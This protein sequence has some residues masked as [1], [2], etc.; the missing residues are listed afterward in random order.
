MKKEY[1]KPEIRVQNFQL[2]ESIAGPCIEGDNTLITTFHDSMCVLEWKGYFT[3]DACEIGDPGYIECT[4]T[5]VE[6]EGYFWS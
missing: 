3:D 6:T 5:Y 4:D 1:K 2:N